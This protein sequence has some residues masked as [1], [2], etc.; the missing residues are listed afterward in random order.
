MGARELTVAR[1]MGAREP[2][3]ARAM[4]ARAR[5]HHHLA[6]HLADHM[7][8]HMADH[9]LRLHHLRMDMELDR[10]YPLLMFTPTLHSSLCCSR[11]PSSTSRR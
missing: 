1:A 8:D 3:V 7:A 2:A 4:G 6:D 5:L 11:T 9:L 10:P